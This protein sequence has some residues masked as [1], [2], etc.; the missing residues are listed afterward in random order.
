MAFLTDAISA[1]GSYAADKARTTAQKAVQKY[2]NTMVNIA[3]A[4][5]QN[6]ITTNT[7]LNIK[8]SARKAIALDRNELTAVGAAT[9]NA[10]AAGVRGNSV[11][12]TVDS[13]QR[14]AGLLEHQRELDLEQQFSQQFN[15]RLNSA[16]SAKQNQDRSY[17]AKPSLAGAMFGAVQGNFADASSIDAKGEFS[18]NRSKFLLGV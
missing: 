9:V 11:D 2:Q 12:N 7:T 6:V 17:I 15:Q 18:F 5:N 8:Q 1:Y 13:I 4:M 3:D 10:A 16:F 14:G